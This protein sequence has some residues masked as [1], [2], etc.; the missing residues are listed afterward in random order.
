MHVHDW[1][2]FPAGTLK[3][4]SAPLKIPGTPEQ[5]AEINERVREQHKRIIALLHARRAASFWS[6]VNEALRGKADA[7]AALA[8][9]RFNPRFTSDA[10]SDVAQPFI[11]GVCCGVYFRF[12]LDGDWRRLASPA[13]PLACS[14]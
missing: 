12:A 2:D 4:L 14:A 3:G 10:C 7:H 9:V 6:G 1:L 13:V 11:C 5:R 8:H